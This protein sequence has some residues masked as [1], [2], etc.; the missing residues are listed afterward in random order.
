M[1]L[2]YL[3]PVSWVSF[4][5]HRRGGCN[6]MVWWLYFLMAHNI[7]HSQILVVVT[8]L[9]LGAPSRKHTMKWGTGCS[10]PICDHQEAPWGSREGR[11]GREK[12][13][14]EMWQWTVFTEG[15]WGPPRD[16]VEPW[17]AAL[18]RVKELGSWST[19]SC[20][21]WVGGDS[22]GRWLP[23]L[24][25]AH[26]G[27]T[28]K[29][30]GRSRHCAEEPSTVGRGTQAP[31]SPTTSSCYKNSRLFTASNSLLEVGRVHVIFQ[32]RDSCIRVG[33][34]LLWSVGTMRAL[35]AHRSWA[36][37][38]PGWLRFTL[39]KRARREKCSPT[40]TPGAADSLP[41]ADYPDHRLPPVPQPPALFPFRAH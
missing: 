34:L 15:S 18:L 2:S 9:N 26:P 23:N 41:E 39:I 31:G 21:S 29:A 22:W 4:R 33:H 10:C 24:W 5:V 25:A 17:L 7:F 36:T 27:E 12:S 13:Q 30:T 14:Q 6:V 32:T 37:A 1:H 28:Q 3:G 40:Q 38:W 8:L 19:I 16:C 11:Q 35:D 20:P